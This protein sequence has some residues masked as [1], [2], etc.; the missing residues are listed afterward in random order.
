MEVR[1]ET[2]SNQPEK[3]K[4]DLGVDGQG[5]QK[6]MRLHHYLGDGATTLA[7]NT[8]SGL[9]GIITYFY[10]DK[11]GLSAATVGT[12]MLLTRIIDA[13]TDLI[14]GKLVDNTKSKYGKARPWLL[15]TTIPT[16]F[17][18]ILLFT[19]PVSA[20]VTMKYVYVFLTLLFATAIVYTAIQVPYGSLM[21]LRTR[22]TEERGKIGITRA[23]FG[24]I[25]GM[26]IAIILIPASNMLGGDQRAWIIIGIVLGVVSSI[27]LLVTFFTSKEE[28]EIEKVEEED[29]VSFIESL[30]LIF[31]NKYFVIALF[32]TLFSQM[33]YALINSTG[34]FYAQHILGDDNL[35][36]I[37]GA[38]GL[39]PTIVGFAAVGPMMKKF[40]LAKTARIGMLIGIVGTGIRVFMPYSFIATLVFG[41]LT[42]FGIIPMMA[43]GGVLVA[44]TIEYGEWQSGKRLVG[45]INSASSFGMKVGL[46]LGTAM[47]G[48]IL[49]FG[50]YDGTLATQPDSAMIS[51]LTIS[52]YLPLVLLIIIYIL[53]RLYSSIA[54]S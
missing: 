19:V 16:L 14:M 25:I 22:S 47:V 54:L 5:I 46:G 24:Y 11:I 18:I 49:A 42:T 21:A 53:L 23:V 17:A 39:I 31:K 50:S 26:I 1:N 13:F 30:K 41:S 6:T 51:I 7:T 48:W 33:Y 9:V 44:N 52:I 28:T 2:I 37:M 27:A 38:V 10:T 20:S 32:I 35:V 12:I 34:P 29:N 36:G 45:M 40:G 15:W 4:K 3:Q 8:I 43:I